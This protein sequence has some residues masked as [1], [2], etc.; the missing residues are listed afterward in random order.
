LYSISNWMS[1]M[2]IEEEEGLAWRIA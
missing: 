2:Q 1:D